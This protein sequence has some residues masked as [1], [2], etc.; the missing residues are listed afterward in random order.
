MFHRSCLTNCLT[1]RNVVSI[2]DLF[3]TFVTG[4][5]TQTESTP[6]KPKETTS[7]TRSTVIITA[8]TTPSTASYVSAIV[9]D[10][11]A[12]PCVFVFTIS[13]TARATIA[14]PFNTI[15]Q[16]TFF[17]FIRCSTLAPTRT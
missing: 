7:S 8:S 2:L 16:V 14:C 6:I 9:I 1:N 17:Y 13:F 4:R 12:A 10:F 15:L 5:D 3:E 11:F